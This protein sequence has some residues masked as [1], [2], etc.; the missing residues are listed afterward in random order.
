MVITGHPQSVVAH[1]AVPADQDILQSVI[2]R[3]AHMQLTGDVRWGDNNTEG[4]LAFFYLSM[5]IT[6]LF[7]EF[8]PFLLYGSRVINL[9]NIMFFAHINFLLKLKKPCP[10]R[11][12]RIIVVPP[13]FLVLLH[14]AL[15]ICNVYQT[16]FPTLIFSKAAPGLHHF[17]RHT[18]CTNRC[19]SFVTLRKKAF[20]SSPLDI[21][22]YSIS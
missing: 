18:A 4:V 20:R 3:M 13:I 21:L 16:A 9:R 10:L 2:Q 22:L 7:P 12:G 17:H 6:M 15:K 11:T 5:K 14:K 1:H 19:F 8:I